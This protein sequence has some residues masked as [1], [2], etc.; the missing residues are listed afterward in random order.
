MT[1]HLHRYKTQVIAVLLVAFSGLFLCNFLCGFDIVS[2]RGYQGIET[3]AVQKHSDGHEDHN[4]HHENA[5]GIDHQENG[6]T[7]HGDHHS[8]DS[9]STDDCCKELTNA[10]YSSLINQNTQVPV[11]NAKFSTIYILSLPEFI[12][13]A[14]TRIR[15]GILL[16]YN[17]PPPLSG[18]DVRIL[19]QSFLN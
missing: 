17:L 19:F 14:T 7:T 6:N 12:I 16:Y 13:N 1:T 4:H 10:I 18:I 3:V 5:T 11:V 9:Q 8:H 2:I 15:K